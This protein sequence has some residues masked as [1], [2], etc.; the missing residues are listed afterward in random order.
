MKARTGD[1]AGMLSS[2]KKKKTFSFGQAEKMLRLICTGSR[3]WSSIQERRVL[4]RG[5][6]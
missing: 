6:V 5:D 3:V 4:K 1:A 2:V